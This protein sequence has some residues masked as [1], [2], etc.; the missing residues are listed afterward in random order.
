MKKIILP[1]V[2]VLA[3]LGSTVALA[4]GSLN[5]P[6]GPVGAAWGSWDSNR[7]G[8]TGIFDVTLSGVPTGYDVSNGIYPGWCVQMLLTQD[9]DQYLLYSSDDSGMPADANALPWDKVNY[10]LNYRPAG[11]SAW[12]VQ[13]AIWVVLGQELITNVSSA[14]AV[15]AQDALDHGAGFTAEPG[16]IVAVILYSDGFAGGEYDQYQEMIIEVTLPSRGGP[17]T[18][19]P[20]Y[21]KN[22]PDAWP[23]NSITIGEDTYSKSQAIALLGMPDGDKSYTMFRGYV[24]AFLNVQV[25]NNSSCITNELSAAYNWL[26]MYEPG[27]GVKANSAA[28]KAGK[29]TYTTL[30][31]YN[32]GLLCAP[33]RN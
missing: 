25:G 1:L 28:W 7:N 6:G 13:T 16:Q 32:N 15:M 17:G 3:L 26:N 21:W 23:V 29:S 18:G 24:A 11:V 19:T 14:A 33:H 2:L 5:L 10:L 4:A 9:T 30:D 27:S 22:H 20:G 31:N 8:M 12:D